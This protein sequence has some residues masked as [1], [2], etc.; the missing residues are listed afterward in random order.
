M[1]KYLGKYKE[2]ACRKLRCR[3]RKISEMDA[4]KWDRNARWEKLSMKKK[5]NNLMT[6]TLDTRLASSV[7]R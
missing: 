1:E 3:K 5:K 2:N 6:K 4:M 7:K